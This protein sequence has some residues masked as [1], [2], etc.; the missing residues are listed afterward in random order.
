MSLISSFYGILI[1]MY[2]NEGAHSLPHFPSSM[3][4]R[5][6]P[7]HWTAPTSAARSRRKPIRSPNIADVESEVLPLVHI[8]GVVVIGDHR[9]RLLFEDG[10]VGDVSFADHDWPGV[11][12]PLRD[13][14][15]FAKVTAEHGT[16]YWSGHDLDLAPEPL[17]QEALRNAVAQP[18]AA[19]G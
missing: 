18:A 13:P 19:A 14:V 8:K 11:L 6:P 10:T 7:S 5:R 16:L 4:I 1:R 3:V 9:V 15:Y 2:Y 17:Y 12:A